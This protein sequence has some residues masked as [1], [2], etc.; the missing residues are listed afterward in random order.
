MLFEKDNRV[1]AG[2]T[3]LGSQAAAIELKPPLEVRN[4][5]QYIA[6]AIPGANQ[7]RRGTASGELLTGDGSSVLIEVDLEAES[8]KRYALRS[9]S[10]GR[11]LM[12]S[13]LVPN[14]P[15]GASDLPK[16]ER[17]VRLWLRSIPPLTAQEVRWSDI[18]NK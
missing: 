8:G 3:E 18:T 15:A 16:S 6:L 1:L 5:V 7:W 10:F 13:H 9:P 12:F 2:R 14:A 11:E 4:T 17:F